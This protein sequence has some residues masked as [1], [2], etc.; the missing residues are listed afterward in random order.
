MIKRIKKLLEKLKIKKGDVLF[1]PSIKELRD[2]LQF[3]SEMRL[4]INP[5]DGMYYIADANDYTHFEIMKEINITDQQNIEGGLYNDGYVWL[6]GHNIKK[7]FNKDMTNEEQ[8]EWFYNTDLY[9]N[10]K[11][12]ITEVDIQNY[13]DWRQT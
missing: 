3:T 1:S 8:L 12:F 9:K 6:R 2:E 10:L 4:V 7:Y 13:F 11:N 5:K